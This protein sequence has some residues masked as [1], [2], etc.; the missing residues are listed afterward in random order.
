MPLLI[1]LWIDD[2]LVGG[3][4]EWWD[5]VEGSLAEPGAANE[6]PL[7]SRVDPYGDAVIGRDDLPA[8]AVEARRL[9]PRARERARP[10]LGKLASL[11]DEGVRAERSELRFLGD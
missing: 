9:S 8:L 10:L 6:F 2:R 5:D 1:E 4:N 7:L 3:V 11:C